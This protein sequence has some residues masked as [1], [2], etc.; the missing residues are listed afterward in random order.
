MTTS[1]HKVAS[2][3]APGPIH[4]IKGL[5][6]NDCL[7]MFLRWTFNEG[8]DKQY[9]KLMEIGKQIVKKMQRCSFGCGV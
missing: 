4:N 2:V 8:E 7:L 9:P 6:E 1:S 3:M 5:S